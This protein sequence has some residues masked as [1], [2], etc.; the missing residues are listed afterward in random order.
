M[1]LTNYFAY[2][3]PLYQPTP[4]SIRG[5]GR[6]R[7]YGRGRVICQVCNKPRHMALQMLQLA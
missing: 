7:G 6:G 1:Q 3:G 2:F 5:R 4:N